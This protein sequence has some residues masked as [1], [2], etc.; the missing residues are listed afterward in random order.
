MSESNPPIVRIEEG[1]QQARLSP[2]QKKFN[3]TIRKIDR[4]K[5]LLAVWQETIPRY[6]Q[7]VGE[8]FIPL[9]QT[10]AEHQVEMVHLLDARHG[11]KRITRSQQKKIEHLVCELCAELISA[12]DRE[13]LKPIY[14]KYSELDYDTRDQEASALA[15]DF[16]KS[17]LE[18]ELGI[19]LDDDDM[20]VNSPEK[21]AAF[22]QDRLEEQ[23]RQAIERSS[24]RKKTAKQLEK[25]ARL[26]AEEAKLGKSLQAVYRQLVAALHPDREQDPVERERKTGLMQQVTVAYDRKD[27]LLLLELQLTV[28]QIDQSR[29]NTIAADRLKYFNKILQGQLDQLQQ[30]VAEIEFMFKQQAGLAPYETLTPERLISTIK[31]DI[32]GLRDEI[33]RI[34]HDLVDFQGINR[35]RSWLKSYRIPDDGMAGTADAVDGLY[36]RGDFPPF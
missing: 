31:Q 10:F 27:L 5:Q 33:A 29:I 15:G 21:M 17:M 19:Q 34:Q 13:D 20:D 6:Q 30:E 32:D 9:R 24:R 11:D 18:Y 16:I 14:N 36:F 8:K 3:A 28:E 23:Q 2:A 22:V 4:Q 25:E 12:H 26:Q 7:L 1:Q 35:L